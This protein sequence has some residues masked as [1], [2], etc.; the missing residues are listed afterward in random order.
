MGGKK[1]YT[2]THTFDENSVGIKGR[3]VLV[4]LHESLNDGNKKNS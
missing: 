1:A 2:I 3:V 4:R